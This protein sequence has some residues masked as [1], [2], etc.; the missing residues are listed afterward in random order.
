MC[1]DKYAL[2]YYHDM[3]IFVILCFR[4]TMMTCTWNL[5]LVGCT[6]LHSRT[7][8]QMTDIYVLWK[9]SFPD[10]GK[11]N[12]F[13]FSLPLSLPSCPSW[14]H[15]DASISQ[16]GSCPFSYTHVSALQPRSKQLS[17][18]YLLTRAWWYALTWSNL[19]YNPSAAS[20]MLLCFCSKMQMWKI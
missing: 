8:S 16:A 12:K 1:I 19:W 4:K 6:T 15:E 9:T 2:M 10:D 7:S 3:T 17:T 13:S 11:S 5:Q 18:Y 14:A 20:M